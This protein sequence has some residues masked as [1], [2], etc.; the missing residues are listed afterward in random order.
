MFDVLRVELGHAA[1]VHQ[2]TE[3]MAQ[4]AQC[5]YTVTRIAY[6]HTPFTLQ[7]VC[8]LVVPHTRLKEHISPGGN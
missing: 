3:R 8:M 2:R 6:T 7:Y 1:D 5:Q 4:P